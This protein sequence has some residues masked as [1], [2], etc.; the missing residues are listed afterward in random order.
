MAEENKL[1][2][3]LWLFLPTSLKEENKESFG[4]L[5]RKGSDQ[6]PRLQIQAWRKAVQPAV[7][8][9]KLWGLITPF[10]FN[11]QSALS[12]SV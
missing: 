8:G 11:S 3:F 7:Q 12:L 5:N 10:V 2:K 4:S 1:L 9:F 6:T